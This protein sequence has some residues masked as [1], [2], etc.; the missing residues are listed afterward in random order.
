MSKRTRGNGE[1]TAYKI[2]GSW[3]AEVTLGW[4]KV[5]GSNGKPY[6][7]RRAK[8]KS[9]FKLKKD[10][11]A[12]IRS[13]DKNA[14]INSKILF[15]ELYELWSASHYEKIAQDTINGYKLAFKRCRDIWYREF[16]LLKTADLQYI[17]DACKM[18]RRTKEDIRILFSAMYKY[19]IQNDYSI[20]NYAEF[21]TL[22]KKEKSKRD[23]FTKEERDE[24][25]RDYIS[26]NKFTGEILFMIYC[27]L[28]FGE[29]KTI[30]REK[31]FLDKKYFIAGIKT[32]AGINREIPI[33]DR[34]SGIAEEL[35]NKSDNKY[36]LS[37]YEK[38]WYFRYHATLQR[39]GIRNLDAHCCRHTT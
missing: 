22:P 25:W 38:E 3:R 32:K 1:G 12:W 20:K 24:L 34:I 5:I 14:P 39:L 31:M 4:D 9:G 29:Y 18:S 36:L 11:L 13:F 15:K 2:N 33:I 37:I 26:G 6:K 21:V 23:A 19:A 7:K 16:N 10:A 27:G 17:V 8:T 35:Y 30:E 28:R